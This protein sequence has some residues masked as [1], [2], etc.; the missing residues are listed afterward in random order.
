[1]VRGHSLLST[2]TLASHKGD[3]VV[4]SPWMLAYA[5]ASAAVVMGSGL[6]VF[7]RQS[8]RFAEMA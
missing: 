1:M 7:R 5:I 8:G 2:V 6:L 3:V 4:W